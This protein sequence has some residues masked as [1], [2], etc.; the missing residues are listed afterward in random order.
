M[1]NRN[2]SNE[3]NQP[4][5]IDATQ[6]IDLRKI[7]DKFNK[8]FANIG[9]V[10]EKASKSEPTNHK[11][12]LIKNYSFSFAGSNLTSP[13]EI[14]NVLHKLKNKTSFGHDEIP[15]TLLKSSIANITEPLSI[16]IKHSVTN[17]CFP[18]LLNVVKIIPVFKGGDKID[19]QNYHSI[20]ILPNFSK[21]F[22][23]V[24]YNCLICLN[25]LSRS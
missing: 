5:N 11:Y 8:H 24:M 15:V 7:A 19:I 18:D 10:R 6:T 3:I 23:R 21:I 17:G 4:F 13:N 1:L 16:I 2:S 22:K 14:I 12:Y 9:A 25:C 20:S